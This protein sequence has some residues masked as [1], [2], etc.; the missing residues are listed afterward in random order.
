[1]AI[2]SYDLP[3]FAT[4][5][6]CC[7]FEYDYFNFTIMAHNKRL[8]LNSR[9]A[10]FAKILSGPDKGFF[11]LEHYSVRLNKSKKKSKK[12]LSTGRRLTIV[13]S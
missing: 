2:R 11:I 6:T 9:A 5:T 4:T 3:L 8:L 7:Y 1:M 12:D 13:Q 10:L